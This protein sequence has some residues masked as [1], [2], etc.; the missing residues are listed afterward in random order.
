MPTVEGVFGGQKWKAWLPGP[1]V[2][3]ELKHTAAADDAIAVTAAER[4]LHAGDALI[5]NPL[6]KTDVEAKLVPFHG[7]RA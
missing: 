7:L 2:C 5:R 6:E 1:G 3:L 4:R